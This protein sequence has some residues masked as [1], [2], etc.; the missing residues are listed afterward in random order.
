MIEKSL[1][2]MPGSSLI[3]ELLGVPGDEEAL[4]IEIEN[5]DSVTIDGME[6][7]FSEDSGPEFDANLAELLDEEALAEVSD[8]LQDFYDT[9]LNSRADW[10]DTY[11]QG[12]EL[13]G[14]RIE[15][16]TE[17]WDGACGVTH[18][19]LAEAAVRFQAETI[20]E[21]FPATGPVKTKIIGRETRE[22]EEA[23]KRVKEDMNHWIVDKMPDYRA[24]HERLLWNL[25]LSGVAFK[26]VYKDIALNRPV[27]KFIAAEDFIAPYGYTDLETTPR[28]AHRLRYTANDIRRLQLSGFYRDV[29]LGDPSVDKSHLGIHEAKDK[30]TGMDG[31][32]DDRYTVLEYHVDLDLPGFEHEQDGSPTGLELP[33][34]VH[35]LLD[36][37]EVLAIY[38]NWAEGDDRHVRRMHFVKYPYI[39]GFGFYDFGLIHLVGGY[40]KG[41]TSLLRQLVD[42]GTLSNLPGGLKTRGLRIKGDDAPIAPGEFRDV[43]VPSG[44]IRDNIM[45]LPYKEPSPVLASLLAAIVEEGRRFAA[46]AD[47]NV[48]DMQPNAPVGSTLALLERTLKPM[49]AIQAR[50]HEAMRKEFKLLK[51]IIRTST[52]TEYAYE[53]EYSGSYIK[54]SDY[55]MVEVLPVSDPNASTM[56]QRIAQYQAALQLAQTAPQLYDMGVLHRQMLEVLG[57]RNA[58]KILPIED[59]IMP[60]DPVTENMQLIRGKPLKAFM[61]QDHEAHIKVHMAFAEDPKVQ[62]LM[63]NHPQAQMMT[64]ALAAHIAEHL[65]FQYR[66]QIEFS[67]GVPMHHPD[68]HLPEDVELEVS[69]LSAA[70][71]DKVLQRNKLEASQEQAQQQAQD[72]IIQ[73]QMQDSQTKQA[74]VQ[75]KQAEVQRKMQKD[76]MDFALEQERLKI[77]QFKASMPQSVP[78]APPPPP[79]P[80]PKVLMDAQTK[81]AELQIKQSEVQIKQSELQLKEAE[82]QRKAKKDLMDYE[83]NQAKLGQQVTYDR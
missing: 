30:Q 67:L 1:F 52:S 82:L 66:Q 16:R 47:V 50:V 14:L 21:T 20:M 22:R 64:A 40:A 18:P 46:I 80:D 53:P 57:I 36:T 55:D 4:V 79:G 68:Q 74:D 29:E 9:D 43:D 35:Y 48:A 8:Q 39:P 78:P 7:D 77:E 59:D 23:A 27:A 72:P 83:T 42:A 54:Q 19:M 58:D 17:P 11:K 75:V 12:L 45:N 32:D 56:S 60:T 6:I 26:K 31:A 51:E 81:Q 62:E 73:L 63:G 69:R 44:S 38:R 65:A 15:H 5:P 41:S 76:Q 70:A 10:E 33:Y 71:A 13:L 34:V 61:Y 24:E 2:E 3:D 28:Y 49:S 25:P 37:N